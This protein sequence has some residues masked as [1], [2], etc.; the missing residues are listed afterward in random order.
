MDEDDIPGTKVNPFG[1]AGCRDGIHRLSGAAC[2]L[3][4]ERI[5]G[6]PGT[7]ACHD[8]GSCVVGLVMNGERDFG[9][10]HFHASL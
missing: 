6:C 8:Q 3:N 4:D 7:S 10:A 9:V 5:K 2:T 1:D